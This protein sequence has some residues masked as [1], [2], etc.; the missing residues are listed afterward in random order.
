MTFPLQYGLAGVVVVGGG[1]GGSSGGVALVV[2]IVVLIMVV[3]VVVS[4][5]SVPTVIRNPEGPSGGA[6]RVQ[7]GAALP[8]SDFPQ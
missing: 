3:L 7:D 5:S 2:V 6:L 1:G 8:Q 4:W